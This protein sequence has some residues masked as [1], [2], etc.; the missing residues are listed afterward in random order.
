MENVF[1]A[2]RTKKQAA[3]TTLPSGKIDLNPEPVKRDR[4]EHFI[5]TKGKIPSEE[6]YNSK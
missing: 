5:L 3:V 2:N 1:Q 6:Y 4:K